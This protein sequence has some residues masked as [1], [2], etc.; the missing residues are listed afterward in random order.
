MSAA[1]PSTFD[2]ENAQNLEDME[3]QFAVKAVQQMTTYW[4]ILEKMPGSKLRLTKMDDEIY[5]H[6]MEVFPEF[7]PAETIDEDKMKSKEGKE[8]WRS[9]IMPYEKKVD[10]YNF[11]T[12]LR[13]N[14]KFEYGE[15]ET[16]FAVRMQ[17]Y[18]VEIARNRAGLNDWIY[19]QANPD[20]KSTSPNNATSSRLTDVAQSTDN[21]HAILV[22]IP[23][24]SPV[25]EFRDSP[26]TK[27]HNA[28]VHP[29]FLCLKPGYRGVGG[30]GLALVNPNRLFADAAELGCDIGSPRTVCL[31]VHTRAIQVLEQPRVAD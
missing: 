20:K 7:D 18:A 19:E 4:A 8:R 17:F 23:G 16:I 27:G 13:S 3:K 11:G 14:P 6:F 25:V 22:K 12:M 28:L 15:K 10:D 2:P 5:E 30:N 26:A 21:L 1:V 24:I 9:F 29:P 31:E